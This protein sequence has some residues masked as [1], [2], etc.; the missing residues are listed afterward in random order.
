[1]KKLF[2]HA[3]TMKKS[4]G[5]PV[6]VVREAEMALEVVLA[7]TEP[8][9]RAKAL[10]DANHRLREI[11][12][13]LYGDMEKLPNPELGTMVTVEIF[14][15]TFFSDALKALSSLDFDARRDVAQIVANLQR[16]KVNNHLVGSDYLEAHTELLDLL[17]QG[18]A[19]ADNALFYG[20]MLRD[21]IRHQAVA[22]YVL[23][24]K[25][26]PQLFVHMEAPNFE[27]SSDA[28]ATFKELLTRHKST[29]AAF[30]SARYEWFFA[31]YN[32]LLQSP[33]YITRR[34]AV[35]MLVEILLEKS[36]AAVAKRY[37]SSLTNLRIVMNMLRE[38][39]KSI[40]VEAIHLFTMFLTNE[41]R[42]AEVTNVL[43]TNKDKLL[44]LFADFTFEREDP[45]VTE[46]KAEVVRIISG[47]RSGEG[48]P[49]V[50]AA[51]S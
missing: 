31:E 8:K 21:C 36:N 4:H 14:R 12:G 47:L 45:K 46:E 15:G 5:G 1:M 40:Q 41:E 24:S 35:K 30:L 11:K 6:D 50:A 51:Q 2:T 3:H 10:E 27:I 25:E 13:I 16:Q 43:Y 18:Y 28:A 33:T 23:D 38:T 34:M 20:S 42:P 32:K 9:V 48:E 17:M 7:K 19:D 37:M 22:K 26:F 49:P 29:A 44:R 39:S